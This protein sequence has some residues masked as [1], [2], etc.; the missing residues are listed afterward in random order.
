MFGMA[1]MAALLAGEA[2]AETRTLHRSGAWSAFGGT[3]DSGT[4]IC[5]VSTS[6]GGRYV[7]LK[8]FG[9]TDHITVHIMKEGWAIPRG[10]PIRMEIEFAGE[11]PWAVRARGYGKLVEF[12]IKG[13]SIG[14]F[15]REFRDAPSGVVRFLD[16]D[17]GGW[18]ISLAG[19]S[20][21]A[22]AMADC[23]DVLADGG[24]RAPPQP[25]GGTPAAPSQPFAPASPE[26]GRT[27]PAPAS[28]DGG[29]AGPAPASPEGG[30]LRNT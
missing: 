13:D 15:V 7:G 24:R 23:V 14:R 21:A 19:S 18:R 4:P 25:S 2:G 16:G 20:A 12:T 8:Y 11:T 10:T 29:K 26:G 1:A 17:E 30:R 3:A 9:G 6:A 22:A 28:P 5:G 27:G